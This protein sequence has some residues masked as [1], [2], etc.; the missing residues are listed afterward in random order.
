MERRSF[1]RESGGIVAL[2]AL[3]FVGLRARGAQARTY[4]RLVADPAGMLEL[5]PGFSYRILQRAGDRMSDGAR[6]RPA[7]DGMAAFPGPNGT[8]ILMRNHELPQGYGGV[9]RVVVDTET[10]RVVSS[11]DVLRGTSVNCAGGPSPWGWLTC[12][13]V[14]EVGGVWLCPTDAARTLEGSER[15]RIDAYGSFKHEAVALDPESLVAYLTEDEGAS[16]LY[17]MVPDDAGKDPFRGTLFAAKRR[18]VDDFDTRRMRIGESFEIE[19]VRVEPA[20]ARAGAKASRSAIFYRGEGI[21][22][23]EGAA[24]FCA[25]MFA[26]VFRLT[27]TTDGGTVTLVANDFDSPDNI[28]VAPWGDLYV[29]EDSQS[30]CRLRIVEA[31]G[32]VTDFARNAMGRGEE[33]AGVCFSP[34][35]KTLFVNLQKPGF[36]VAIRG[37]FERLQGPAPETPTPQTLSPDTP[38]SRENVGARSATGCSLARGVGVD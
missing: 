26:Q 28:T 35:G 10:L 14:S 15:R 6:V 2:G 27:P 31:S 20:Q 21:W 32:R 16:H 22:W 19:W 30:H 3:G 29:A 37:P 13:E 33:F 4:G 7:L 34:D 25:T 36:T 18:G 38:P 23:F 11:N 24:Y 5:P 8:T 12:E 9:S 1:L 17:R